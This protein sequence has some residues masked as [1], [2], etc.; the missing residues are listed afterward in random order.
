MEEFKYVVENSVFIKDKWE[1]DTSLLVKSYGVG[2]QTARNFIT[3]VLKANVDLEK[4]GTDIKENDTLFFSRYITACPKV[5]LNRDYDH[6]YMNVP[7]KLIMGRF[8]CGIRNLG[9]LDMVY[10]KILIEPIKDLKTGSIILAGDNIADIGIVKKVGTHGMF[11][12]Y[13][14]REL[15]VKVGDT[16]LYF[17]NTGTDITLAGKKYLALPEGRVIAIFKNGI[18]DLENLQM[19]D[20]KILLG[21]LEDQKLD[22]A[23]VIVLPSKSNDF[24][25]QSNPEN[26]YRV[27]RISSQGKEVRKGIFQDNQGIKEGDTLVV[28]GDYLQ[29]VYFKSKNYFSL[30]D[31]ACAEGVI[32]CQQ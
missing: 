21:E 17:N 15:N 24:E 26:M 27:L 3:K 30:D 6:E 22:L 8:N 28:Q 19:L 20:G 31:L 12:D 10:D 29:N 32:S 9:S 16:V 7:V 1:E 5:Y 23:S 18:T 11:R 25:F 4:F 2:L 13:T 14:K